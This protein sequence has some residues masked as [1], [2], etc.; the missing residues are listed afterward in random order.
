MRGRQLAYLEAYDADDKIMDLNLYKNF[1]DRYNDFSK[2][3]SAP[4]GAGFDSL[5]SGFH[6]DEEMI[7]YIRRE[8]ANP[9]AMCWTEEKRIL[10]VM[11]VDVINYQAIKILLEE[12][13]IKVYEC[14]LPTLDE[15]DFFLPTY[16]HY[17]S[18][19]PSC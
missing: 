3:A 13:K 10:V 2:L 11:N 16:I 6:W 15:A 18:C 19:S 8:R 17:W 14:N 7:K 1:K 5:V 12:E 9:R 4:S